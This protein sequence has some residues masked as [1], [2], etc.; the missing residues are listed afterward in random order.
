LKKSYFVFPIKNG[1]VNARLKLAQLSVS[2][3]VVN[4]CFNEWK[5]SANIQSNIRQ[6]S[7]KIFFI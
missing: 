4:H 5:N 7:E 6:K 1:S 3:M 2:N